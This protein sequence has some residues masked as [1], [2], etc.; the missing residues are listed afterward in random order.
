MS[1]PRSLFALT[2]LAFAAPA[3][4]GDHHHGP[5]HNQIKGV[6]V[7]IHGNIDR[8]S[9]FGSGARFEFAVVPD[10][11]LSGNVRDELALSFGADI[12]FAPVDLGWTYWD[13]EPYA[14]PIAAVQWNF[15]LGERWS[16]FP[17]VGI[18]VHAG[19]NHDY[20][21]DKHGDPHNW[22]YPEPDVGFGARYHFSERVALL[23]RLSTPGGLQ[24]GLVF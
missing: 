6:R 12:F 15:Y 2:G 10:G 3:L 9:V 1:F 14:V 24:V 7:D 23:M 19:F 16:I 22:L 4:A 17:E 13:G 5:D 21:Y 18:A 20:W 11:F 8:N